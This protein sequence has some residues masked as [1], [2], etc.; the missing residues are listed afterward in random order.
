MAPL[1]LDTVRAI[2]TLR[3]VIIVLWSDKPS[4]TVGVLICLQ[5]ERVIKMSSQWPCMYVG[6]L[7]CCFVSNDARISLNVVFVADGVSR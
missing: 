5:E 1:Y 6:K 4:V 7:T 2:G 3:Y